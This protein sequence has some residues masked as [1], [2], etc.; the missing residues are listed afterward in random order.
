MTRSTVLCVFPNEWDRRQLAACRDRWADRFDVLF[1]EPSDEDCA[2][3]YDVV[4]FVERMV[5][6]HRGRI[7]GVFSSSDYPGAV[8]AAAI[9]TQ[10]GL[11]GVPPDAI[12]RTSHKA[13]SRIS[14][15][16][17]VPEATPPFVLID[18][19]RP[20]SPFFPCFVKPV[21]GAFSL[22]TKK[23]ETPEELTRFLSRPAIKTFR[24]DYVA[25]FNRLLAAWSDIDVDAGWFV[26]EGVL[27]GRQVTVEGY[28]FD[29]DFRLL[30]VSDSIIHPGTSSFA[31]FDYPSALS[32]EIRAK[33]ADLAARAVLGLGLTHAQF[34]V[35]L[36][37]DEAA[38]RAWIIEVNPRLAGQFADLYEKV[39]D[40][41]AYEVA[42]HLA[43]GRRPGLQRKSGPFDFAASVPLRTFEPV[44][45]R[46]VPDPAKIAAVEAEFPGTLVWLECEAGQELV[47]FE[48]GEDGSSARYAIVNVGAADRDAAIDKAEAVRRALG[49]AFESV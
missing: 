43:V 33:L 49:I 23:C 28:T 6:E 10:L 13:A 22:H 39:H 3:D 45:V 9:A 29:G 19:D 17:S 15:A 47:D 24:H 35:E 36:F 40:K 2:W 26:G 34:N 21:K 38:D 31:R 27:S 20:E 16:A 48:S 46:A 30:G 8:A 37:Y 7:D 11:P 4:Q 25:I 12:L 32:P 1:A 5:A 18:P 14:Q 44:K 42:L 41:N